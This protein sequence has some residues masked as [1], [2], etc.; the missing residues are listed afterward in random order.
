MLDKKIKSIM[1]KSVH[2][3]VTFLHY[4][5]KV[6]LFQKKI[7]KLGGYNQTQNHKL[8]TLKNSG[9]VSFF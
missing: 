5:K 8:R 2:K 9:R 7:K 1:I 4:D 6:L 3:Y